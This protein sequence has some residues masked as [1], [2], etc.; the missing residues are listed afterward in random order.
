[1]AS[2]IMATANRRA[3][4]P[5]AIQLFLR[6]DYPNRE[7]IILDDGEESVAD[8]IPDEERIRYLRLTQRFSMGTKHNM[9]CEMAQGA[10]IVHWDDDD[11]QAEWRLSYQIGE[12]L[13]QSPDTLC[14]LSRVLFYEPRSNRAWEYSYPGGRSWVLGATFCYR[15]RFWER[16][17]FPDMNEGADTVFV[18]N[19]QNANVIAHQDSRFFVGTVHSHNT[20]PKRT[21]TSGWRTLS[22]E[23][24]RGLLNSQDWSF[25]ERFG[26]QDSRHIT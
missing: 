25:Y 19:L 4:V 12:L 14:G 2:C 20:S 10:V 23:E 7:L 26:V 22:S 15:K 5:Q 8:L 9:A 13:Q 3:F 21:E 18:W 17:R 6:Q 1:L 16:N 24:I 11:W